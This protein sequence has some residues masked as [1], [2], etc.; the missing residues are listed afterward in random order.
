MTSFKVG[1]RVAVY[2]RETGRG[3]SGERGTIVTKGHSDGRWGIRFDEPREILHS[4]DG[5]VPS[6]TGY[7]VNEE[8]LKLLPKNIISIRATRT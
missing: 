4:L 6:C 5:T 7:W 3:F 2:G 8:L 1:D